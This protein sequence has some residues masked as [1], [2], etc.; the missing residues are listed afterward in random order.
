MSLDADFTAVGN[1][2]VNLVVL[3]KDLM[4]NLRRGEEF[5]FFNF[6]LHPVFLNEAFC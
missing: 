5:N 4:K 3:F 2:Y 1:T 6:R